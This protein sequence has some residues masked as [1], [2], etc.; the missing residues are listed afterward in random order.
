MNTAIYDRALVK[1]LETHFYE[2]PEVSREIHLDGW[3]RKVR[4]TWPDSS[5]WL[6]RL[7]QEKAE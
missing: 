5:T 1:E 3:T 6:G 2:D 4:P 7:A